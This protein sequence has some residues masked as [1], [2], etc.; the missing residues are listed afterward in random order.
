[1]VRAGIPPSIT[2][3]E[4]GAHIPAGTGVHGMGVKDPIAAAVAAATAGFAILQQT[5]KGIMLAKGATEATVPGGVG[6]ITTGGGINT[7]AEGAAPMVHTACDPT[8][9]RGSTENP[10]LYS[11]IAEQKM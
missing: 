6:L 9:T 7:S 4:P 11:I 1:M 3:G 8:T 10:F 2:F 5:P